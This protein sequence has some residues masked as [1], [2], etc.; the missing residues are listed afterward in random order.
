MAD[1]LALLTLYDAV[2]AQFA[3]DDM[4]AV[5]QPF[6]WR[7]VAQQYVG[8]RI[9]WVPG[10]PA[11]IVGRMLPPRNPGGD[12][13]SLGTLEEQFYVVICGQDPAAPEN[14]RAQYDFTRRLRDFW[15]RAVYR[16]AHGTFQI[17][18]EEWL[19]IENPER[20]YG[21]AIRVLGAIQSKVP[22]V[23]PDGPDYQLAPADTG[24]EVDVSELDNTEHITVEA[25]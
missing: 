15:F 16:A 7:F 20:R 22:D 3:A 2:V 23:A 12:P 13:R 10:N 6:G 24:A 11:G 21:T 18:G 1:K 9:V 17:V 4:T 5:A 8:N 25:P 19:G 14:E